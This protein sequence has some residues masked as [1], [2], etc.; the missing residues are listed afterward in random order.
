MTFT[1]PISRGR[2]FSHKNQCYWFYDYF[3]IHLHM[4]SINLGPGTILYNGDLDKKKYN[5]LKLTAL[6]ERQKHK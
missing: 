6:W 4:L 5:S 2:I 3:F 1:S